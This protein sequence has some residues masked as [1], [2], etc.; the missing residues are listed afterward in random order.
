MPEEKIRFRDRFETIQIV[1]T[2]MIKLTNVKYVD[3]L[4]PLKNPI[5]KCMKTKNP[6]IAH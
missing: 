1:T 3:F 4:V 2:V 6:I 5:K